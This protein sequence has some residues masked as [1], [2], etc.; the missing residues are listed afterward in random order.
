MIKVVVCL[1]GAYVKESKYSRV[2]LCDIFG[3]SATYPSVPQL[4][5]LAA[6]LNVRVDD[7]YKLKEETS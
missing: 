7:L 2:E 3:I 5:K 6:L 1:V 4:W